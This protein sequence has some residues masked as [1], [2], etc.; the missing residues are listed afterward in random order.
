MQ[1]RPSFQRRLLALL[2]FG[3]T[4]FSVGHIHAED[5]QTPEIKTKEVKVKDITLNVPVGW[6]HKLPSSRFRQAEFDIPAVDGDTEPTRL[7]VFWFPGGG[8][9]VKANVPR[10]QK[11][12]RSEERTLKLTRGKFPQGEYAVVDVQGTHV[13]PSFRRRETPLT[14]AQLLAVVLAVK[15][16]GNYFLKLTGP[17]KTVSANAES[18][19][20]SFGGKSKD[21][22]E[23]KIDDPG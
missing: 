14:K 11:E 6:K 3:L 8:G 19:R 13:G 5:E 9:G 1:M 12:F 17:Q 23:F 16:K 2:G 22:Q 20:I 7:V 21:E 18:L 4:V 15:G 10:W